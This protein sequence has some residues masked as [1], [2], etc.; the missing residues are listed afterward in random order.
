MAQTQ[1]HNQSIKQFIDYIKLEKRYSNYTV[2]AYNTDLLQFVE[3]ITELYQVDVLQ[4]QFV[5]IRAWIVHLNANHISKR[6]INRKITSL[7][8]FYKYHLSHRHIDAN[9]VTKISLLK[10][11]KSLPDYVEEES[12][13]LL[14][15]EVDFG[16]DYQGVLDKTLIELLYS[17]GIRLS[18]LV[19]LK[20]ADVDWQS[21]QI[22]VLGKRNKERII[23]LTPSVLQQMKTYNQQRNNC[24]TQGLDQNYYFLTQKGQKIYNKYVY[25]Q[26]KSYLSLVTTISKK[27]PHVLRHTFATHLLNKGADLN[28]IKEILGHAS[29]AATQV[30]THNSIDK[31]KNIY[32]QAHPRA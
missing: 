27:S 15:T 13:E 18:E 30:Y 26:I 21:S 17:T 7:R 1:I 6:S 8:S 32:K 28:A 4:A 10:T 9:P 3:F 19:N 23:P 16:N 14:F 29:L 24:L 22:K 20:Y 11:D 31:L 5:M 2:Q 12:M 25:R